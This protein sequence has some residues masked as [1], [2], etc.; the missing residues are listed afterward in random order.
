MV[1]EIKRQLIE[2]GADPES[3]IG[4]MMDDEVFYREML[5]K[6]ADE[7]ELT[8]LG[9]IARRDPKEGF[10]VAHSLK[11]TAGIL[12]LTP[13]YDAAADVADDLRN[14]P[15]DSLEEDLDRFENETAI[16]F[17]IMGCEANAGKEKD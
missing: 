17:R 9:N 10:R 4:R 14:E 7:A 16:Y 3:A 6:F 2:W 15:K 8:E 11:G 1:T 13:L 5:D 12:G